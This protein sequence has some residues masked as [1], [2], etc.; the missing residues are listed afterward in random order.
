MLNMKGKEDVIKELRKYAK[1]C[2]RIYLATDPDREGEAISWHIAQMLNLDMN[3]NNR[4]L[5]MKS[6]RLV[7]RT[8]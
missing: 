5:S 7:F 2:D 1:K 4:V 8:V 6:L 3:A